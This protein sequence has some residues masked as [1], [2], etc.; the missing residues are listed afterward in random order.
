MLQFQILD[1]LLCSWQQ[2]RLPWSLKSPS[3]YRL[4]DTSSHKKCQDIWIL[5]CKVLLN[6]D[7][8]QFLTQVPSSHRHSICFHRVLPNTCDLLA[9]PQGCLPCLVTG[10]KRYPT[11][12]TIKIQQNGNLGVRFF[13]W[14]N[15]LGTI[16]DGVLDL[17]LVFFSQKNK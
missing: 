10:A 12:L 17:P 8:S 6:P 1:L 3:R 13:P 7:I 15:H 2:P 4:W 14:R 11:T 16:A 5:K 9:G